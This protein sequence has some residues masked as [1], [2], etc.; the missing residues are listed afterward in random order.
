[1]HFNK[2]EILVIASLI[3][4]LVDFINLGDINFVRQV[5]DGFNPGFQLMKLS[6]LDE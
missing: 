2:K 6:L 4:S 5:L 3:T 1:L